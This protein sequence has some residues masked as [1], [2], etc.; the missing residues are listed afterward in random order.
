[1]LGSARERLERVERPL[2]DASR[3]AFL[4][5]PQSVRFHLLAYP[6]L[7]AAN[8][9]VRVTEVRRQET[10]DGAELLVSMRLSRQGAQEQPVNV[11]VQFDI[12][13]A[14]SV[15]TFELT[16]AYVDVKDHRISIERAKAQG[17]GK[18]SI[19]ADSNPADDEFYFAF[20]NAPPRR[21]VIVADIA[22]TALPLRLAAGISPD[23]ALQST[24]EAFS[25]DQLTGVRVGSDRARAVACSFACWPGGR[26]VAIVYRARRRDYVLPAGEPYGRRNVC[27]ALGKLA[28]GQRPLRRQF[29]ARRRRSVRRAP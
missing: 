23:P 2:G 21:T 26:F 17:W 16:G 14:R 24:A 4:E 8:T 27:H 3:D 22:E 20:A 11:P 15:A 19:P 7:P 29:L 25:T 10:S 1:M 13:G 6:G 12:E 28:L 18:V 9:S 5:L